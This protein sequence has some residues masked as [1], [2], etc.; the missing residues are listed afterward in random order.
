MNK[1]AL[2]L[3]KAIIDGITIKEEMKKT[4]HV[5]EWQFNKIIKELVNRDYI[6]KNE[7]I[8]QLKKNTKAI[9]L[10]DI[11]KQF[12]IEKLLHD[13]NEILLRQL[14]DRTTIDSLQKATNLSSTTIFRSLLELESIG[15][16]DKTDSKVSIK[17]VNSK[18][19]LFA[20]LLRTDS[21]LNNIEQ[22]AEIIYRD[23]SKTIKKVP[24]DM[25]AD[26]ELTA[27]SLFH[28]YGVQYHTVFDYYVQQDSDLKLE[29]VLVHAIIIASKDHDKNALIV[30]T[31]FYLKNKEKI[32]LLDVRR[33]AKSYNISDI[34]FDIEAY[35]R[36]NP[37]KNRDLFPSWKEFI[38]KAELYS[39][40][41]ESYIIPEAYPSLFKELGEKVEGYV[42]LYL[43]G[44]ENMRIKKLKDRTKDCDIVVNSNTALRLTIS[45][46]KE[47][48]YESTDRSNLSQEDLRINA[49]NILNHPNRSRIDIF[50]RIIAGKLVLSEKMINRATINSFGNVKL[51]ILS[52]EDIFLLKGVT[53]REGDV[54]DMAKIISA[55]NNFDWKVVWDELIKQERSTLNYFSDIFLENIDELYYHT[56]IR[57]PFYRKLIRHVIDNHINR[58]V[59]NG[60]RSLN[61]VVSILKGEDISEKLLRNR[62][63]YLR[64]KKFL[65]DMS[66]NGEVF[67]KATKR[68]VLNFPTN[69]KIDIR[70]K[71]LR[72]VQTFSVQ[73][74][75]NNKRPIE[76]SRYLVDQLTQSVDKEG[77]R[78]RNMAAGLIYL[79]VRHY[80]IPIQA[81]DIA[82]VAG[83][84][85][86]SLSSS[87]EL[88]R[89]I[90]NRYAHYS[91]I[92]ENFY[93]LSNIRLSSST[94]IS[95]SP[96]FR[97]YYLV[98]GNGK[99]LNVDKNFQLMLQHLKSY[100]D[101]YN[102]WKDIRVK[103]DQYNNIINNNKKLLEEAVK[104]SLIIK[105]PSLMPEYSPDKSNFENALLVDHISE[106][107]YQ[108]IEWKLL[109][110]HMRPNLK[111]EYGVEHGNEFYMINDA[112]L[113]LKTSHKEYAD[114]EKFLK[115]IEDVGKSEELVEAIKYEN[116]S[117][118]ELEDLI[119]QFTEKISRLTNQ[120]RLDNR[121]KGECDKC[122]I[123]RRKE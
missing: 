79:L 98:N 77:F 76:Q 21:E 47:M 71:I 78:P 85:S 81:K 57:P 73:L 87:S 46:L 42:E 40:H 2:I 112:R 68:N 69:N 72:Y 59:R 97:K 94:P 92:V 118:L 123:I 119:K 95:P 82:R 65:L 96:F 38:E 52:N 44:G 58:L 32:D 86:S 61:E 43:L 30:A 3:L 25:K 10:R 111:V 26:G 107:L 50:N 56:G 60:P 113:F 64:K 18:L 41:P 39:V 91:Y 31:I 28:H 80:K 67:L 6:E 1:S 66:I 108:I 100:T 15:A 23:F 120:M 27:F 4:V 101:E 20:K 33:I 12:N 114:V 115:A 70:E 103:L 29:D 74:N 16:I 34:W 89:V 102:M 54:H 13:S 14:V 9:L 105:Y 49:S 83:V 110:N 45:A 35:L 8:I 22:Y 121:V 62:I 55:N 48:G 36:S 117:R 104:S 84:S 7:Q 93:V 37:L 5:K 116:T 63:D 122:L 53:S 19:Y 17:D 75:L 90:L 109:N 99:L 88:V 51:G 11:S 106:L 24:K